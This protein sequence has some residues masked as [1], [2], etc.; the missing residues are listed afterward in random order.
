MQSRIA[1]AWALIIIGLVILFHQLDLLDLNR[2]TI[3]ATISM[4][5]G[6]ILLIKGLNNPEYKGIFGGVFFILFGL[7][8]YF[9]RFNILPIHDYFAIGLILINLGV[10]NL[11]Y[12]LFRK[13]KI[14]NL[15]FGIIFTLTGIPFVASYYYYI[16]SWEIRDIFSTYWPILLI[17]FGIG[18]LAEGLLRHYR[19]ND[20]ETRNT[21]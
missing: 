18:L 2:A 16:P 20:R 8:L 6:V 1:G 19:N 4:A 5:G 11:V 13:T 12:F 15:V 14:S 3:I 9:M 17:L 10:A 7:S 21:V